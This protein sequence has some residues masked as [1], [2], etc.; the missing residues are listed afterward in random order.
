M[1][2][3]LA[4][5]I[6]IVVALLATTASAQ[7]ADRI[8][9]YKGKL[10][11]GQ[12]GALTELGI[13]RHE[14]QLKGTRSG[15]QIR[16]ELIL[17]GSQARALR[18]D[19][20][21]LAV[22]KVS[23]RAARAR[24]AQSVEVFRPYSG[25]GGLREE[26]EQ[27]ARDNRRIAKLV[28]F[29]T[30][31]QGKP[32]V[33]LKVTK[34]PEKTDGR[35]PSVLY[36]GAQHAREWI[37][38]EMNRRLMHYI[39]DG[40][41][42]SRRI[43]KLVD[44]RELWFVPVANPDGYDW[45]FT[46]GQRL[47]RK[48][49]RDNN[50]D[51]Q[52]TPGD[53][54]DLNRNYATKWGY[55]NEGSSPDEGSET[56]RGRGPNSE[57]ETKALDSFMRR[58]G[59]EF[60]V[61]YHS[62]AELLLYGT[63]WQVATPTPDD[64]IYEAM[65]GDDANPAIPGYDPDISAEL[66]T[67]NGDTDTHMTERYGTLGFTPEMSTCEAASDSVAGDEW[68]AE[69]CG[70]GFEFPDDEGLVQA[71]FEKNI[72]FALSVAKSADD[73][74]D[75]ESVVGRRAENFRVDTF[76]V[77]YGD[78]QTVA[79]VAKRAIKGLHM[80]YRI[81]GGRTRTADAREWR[82]GERYGDEND[83]Y[84]AE[85]RGTVRGAD[86]GDRVRVWFEG[87]KKGKGEVRS[88]SFEYRL[89]RDTG[90]DVLIIANEGYTGVNPTYPAGTNSPKY[91]RA[92]RRAIRQ[93]GYRADVWDVDRRGVPHDLGV[94][95]HYDAVLW[96]LGDNRL[97]QDPE[98]ETITTPFGE[99]PDIAVAERQQ[100][101]TMSVR[102]YLNAG[103]KLIHAGETAQYSGLPGIG[104]AVGGLFYGLN[105]D[106]E[107]ECV[108]SSVPG[109]FE[110]CLLLADD[111]RQY[112]LGAFTRTDFANPPSVAGIADPVDGFFGNLAAGDNP[113]DE[114]GVFQP[115]SEVLP[116]DEFP[117]FT[118]QGAAEYPQ[119]QGSPFA[120][121]EG[122][123][124][125]GAL[126]ADSSYM[127]LTKTVDLTAATSAQLQFQLSINTEPSY[128]NVIVE[129]HTPG[130]DNWT[131]LADLNGGTNTGRPAECSDPGFLLQIHPFL[132]HY[133]S[134]PD[135]SGTGSSGTWNR[136]T[137]STGGWDQVAFN[138]AP[139]VGG[140]VELSITYVTDPASG[141]VGAFVDDTRIVI[142]NAV[143]QADGFEGATS[144][145][146]VSPQPAGSPPNSGNWQIGERLLN[147]YAGTSSEDTLL[148]GFGL[149]HLSTDAERADL[150]RRALGGLLGG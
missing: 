28:T 63:G 22:K 46:P 129:A 134:G 61:N 23:R 139:Y 80:H 118:S 29:G 74:D 79:V 105:G 53:G 48:N 116:P 124:Y 132:R 113:L 5:S 138:L 104:D 88:E 78:P 127:R 49:L 89:V 66:Y 100:Y 141:G 144:T 99:L 39:L 32:I 121:V 13:D 58:V 50:G 140:Q 84:Y 10:S 86:R 120:P 24:A 65:A 67:T 103:G 92:H 146:T 117:Q 94:L 81:D 8:Q 25:A 30:T 6:S 87:K 45:S 20:I 40:Y 31:V 131:T 143:T 27:A 41:N 9:V 119:E 26:Y 107:A 55:D 112:Y 15:R 2:R 62:A 73:P 101:L 106:P 14:L 82:G 33:A 34:D 59:F 60:F 111:F 76:D 135:C 1:R 56:Y 71:E 136:F 93:A 123:R 137:A 145:W 95:D 57:P 35:K 69:D 51:G 64:V 122:T 4:A 18:R 126:H 142:N 91:V 42:T 85:F 11:R 97:T 17:S 21:R 54:V 36:L 47:W 19:G 150:V 83:D 70:S 90:D 77:S 96:Y 148:L 16:V 3:A 37:T 52:I 98:D 133:F 12:L 109:F 128:D 114:A 72:P 75:P 7:G 102:D 108:I 147:F 149:E 44:T 125:A 68:E 130:Q 38:P 110:D 43:R 115:T